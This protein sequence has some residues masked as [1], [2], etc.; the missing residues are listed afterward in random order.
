MPQAASDEPTELEMQNFWKV[1]KSIGKVAE[2]AVNTAGRAVDSAGRVV[3]TAERAVQAGRNLG[4][5]QAQPLPQQ[6]SA[7]GIAQALTTVQQ[8][9]P[10]IQQLTALL[11]QQQ[12][13]QAPARLN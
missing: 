6:P 9:L 1:V 10:A 13:Q 12:A 4:L 5:F 11:Q 7:D 8:A 3:D 2:R